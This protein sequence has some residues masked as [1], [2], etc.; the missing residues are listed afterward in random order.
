MTGT[1]MAQPR[2]YTADEAAQI[3][4]C[5]AWWVKE[6]ARHRRIPFCWIGGSY[7]FTD[8]HIVAIVRQSEVAPTDPDPEVGAART[9][10]PSVVSDGIAPSRLR[11]RPP[12]RM[13]GTDSGRSAA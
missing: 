12:R 13:R 10:R 1:P 6:Q 8:E 11:A 4:R 9:V 7:R 3:L 2:V 5:S